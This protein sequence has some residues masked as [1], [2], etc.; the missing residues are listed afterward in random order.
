M[1]SVETAL[2]SSG[3]IADL[4]PERVQIDPLVRI[5]GEL[6]RWDPV[7]E[8]GQRFHE[9][10]LIAAGV[11]TQDPDVVCALLLCSNDHTQWVVVPRALVHRRTDA[12]RG[13]AAHHVHHMVA[14]GEGHV[15]PSDADVIG[16][17]ARGATSFGRHSY[18]LSA[19]GS[20]ADRRDRRALLV[21]LP[22]P[23]ARVPRVDLVS[24]SELL[25]RN[26]LV[27]VLPGDSC[28]RLRSADDPA[29]HGSGGLAEQGVVRLGVVAVDVVA[30]VGGEQRRLDL[31]GQGGEAGV[32]PRLGRD[33]VVLDLD[34]EVV[35]AEDVLEAAGQLH[36]VVEPL[37]LAE[38]VDLLLVG[39]HDRLGH[40]G[41]EH[42]AAQAP[43]GGDE[44]LAVLLEQLPVDLGLAVVALHEGARRQLDQVA[45]ADL[46][47]GEE[48]EVVPRLL[49]AL[50]LAAGVVHLAP[51]RDALGAVVVG[52]VGLGAEDRFDPPVLAGPV[53]VEDPVH[54]AVVGDAEGGLAVGRRGG[55]Q[56]VE[57]SR[58]VEHGVLGVDVQVGEGVSHRH[59]SS[60]DYGRAC[61][62]RSLSTGRPQWRS[63]AVD[64]SHPCDSCPSGP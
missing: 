12:E 51:G 60:C 59:L 26:F 4:G 41:L 46:V 25:D 42:V 8:R 31:L 9:Q 30:V 18:E 48:R 34:E 38:M 64:K 22:A 20:L 53:E 2:R 23:L 11:D 55:D 52:H 58:P 44:A 17:I 29:N 40:H 37:V 28:R 57:A 6:P 63:T 32:R 50:A 21:H 43:G 45:V 10:G 19:I 14:G 24:D 27:R 5:G 39:V 33:A 1:V 54:V 56:L 36:R 35:A 15:C 62:E 7:L 16:R 13:P 61:A 49:A 3:Q 47:L